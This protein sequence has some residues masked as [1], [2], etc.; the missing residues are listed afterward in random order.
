MGIFTTAAGR[1]R[2]WVYPVI[3]IIVLPLAGF[4]AAMVLQ[5]ERFA[6]DD[7]CVRV[8]DIQFA[9]T[10]TKA[11]VVEACGGEVDGIR[12]CALVEIAAG[13]SVTRPDAV[14]TGTVEIAAC[15]APYVPAR[16]VSPLNLSLL[17]DSCRK[18]Q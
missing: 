13:A 17:V 8:G 7:A 3:V 1:L 18:P 4:G 16:V 14:A 10:C 2:K 5:P 15:H 6:R 9:N 12:R 11:I